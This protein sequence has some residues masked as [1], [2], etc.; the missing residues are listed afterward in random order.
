[1]IFYDKQY[2]IFQMWTKY[3]RLERI[4]PPFLYLKHLQGMIA[5]ESFWEG[6]KWMCKLFE[7]N[8]QQGFWKFVIFLISSKYF[9]IELAQGNLY[10]FCFAS[11]LELGILYFFPLNYNGNNLSLKVTILVLFSVNRYAVYI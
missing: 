7:L 8:A 6:F 9:I 4:P 5:R 10:Q 1:M 3:A 11:F 2:L